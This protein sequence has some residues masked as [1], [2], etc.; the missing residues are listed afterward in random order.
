M[1]IYEKETQFTCSRARMEAFL[2]LEEK[3]REQE[4]LQNRLVLE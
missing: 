3:D 1:G 2:E 4:T